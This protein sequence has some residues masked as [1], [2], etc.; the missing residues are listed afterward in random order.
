MNDSL[1]TVFEYARFIV[2]DGRVITG[3]NNVSLVTHDFVDFSESNI[4]RPPEAYIIKIESPSRRRLTQ[5]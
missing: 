3:N 5:K 1:D 4:T 2:Q